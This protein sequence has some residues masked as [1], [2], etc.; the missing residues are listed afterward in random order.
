MNADTARPHKHTSNPEAKAKRPANGMQTR[1]SPANRG[2]VYRIQEAAQI[3]G[4]SPTTV[5]LWER[6]GLVS[7][8]RGSNGYRYFSEADLQRLRRIAHLRKVEGLNVE[9][10]RRAL[11]DSEESSSA[12]AP[13]L[14]SAH[15]PTIGQRFRRL[16]L[17]AALTLGQ[18][19]AMAELSPSFLSALERDQ[20]GISSQSL[21]RLSH[22]YGS[23]VSA[24]LRSETTDLVQLSSAGKR[25]VTSVHGYLVLTVVSGDD[26]R[27]AARL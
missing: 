26:V 13:A 23:T 1:S 22:A 15:H 24:L 11:S 10:I 12:S 6:N 5:R 17:D 16:R 9:G 7:S 27:V 25:K 21:H 19:A 8:H 3:A 14:A 2:S 4:V 20:T 18:A